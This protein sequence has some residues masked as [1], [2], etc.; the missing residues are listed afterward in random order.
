MKEILCNSL[1]TSL[2]IRIKCGPTYTLNA[3]ASANLSW[4]EVQL[5]AKHLRIK[6][7]HINKKSCITMYSKQRELT[8]GTGFAISAVDPNCF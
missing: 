3:A 6:A 4:T 5:D 7:A 8:K 2:W 1:Y